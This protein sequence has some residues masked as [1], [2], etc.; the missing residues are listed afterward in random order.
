[1][2]EGEP[3]F[4]PEAASQFHAPANQPIEGEYLSEEQWQQHQNAKMEREK[5]GYAPELLARPIEHYLEKLVLHKHSPPDLDTYVLSGE[6]LD[7]DIFLA[8][9]EGK[10]LIADSFEIRS[11][12]DMLSGKLKGPGQ[13]ISMK[14]PEEIT[15]ILLRNHQERMQKRA[16]NN[17]QRPTN[18]PSAETLNV[19]KERPTHL[20]PS[21]SLENDNQSGNYESG[22]DSHQRAS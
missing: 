12:Y 18:L 5:G 8:T 9:T 2:R 20:L 10:D 16:Q 19:P 13:M 21:S 11:E 14:S 6:A 1:M 17:P 22:E 4:N 15:Q 3:G 7:D